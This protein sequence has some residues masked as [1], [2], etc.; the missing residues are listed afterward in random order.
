M[1]FWECPLLS[2]LCFLFTNFIFL[3]IFLFGK[4]N[5]TYFQGSCH[6]CLIHHMPCSVSPAVTADF[7]DHIGNGTFGIC[8]I[9]LA[10]FPKHSPQYPLSIQIRYSVCSYPYGFRW[11][12]FMYFMCS[13][14]PCLGDSPM[15]SKARRMYSSSQKTSYMLAMLLKITGGRKSGAEWTAGYISYLTQPRKA[16][17]SVTHTNIQRQRQRQS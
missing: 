5:S 13:P 17:Q 6:T 14:W 4:E 1:I 3:L 11:S 15:S 12:A 9:N 16:K 8:G 2:T 7:H 10:L